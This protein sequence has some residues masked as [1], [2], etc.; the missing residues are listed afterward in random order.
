MFVTIN[1]RKNN[2]PFGILGAPGYVWPWVCFVTDYSGNGMIAGLFTTQL[3][4]QQYAAK[5]G[6]GYITAACT[7]SVN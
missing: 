2:L 7:V 6:A 3:A 4:A 1:G 5:L